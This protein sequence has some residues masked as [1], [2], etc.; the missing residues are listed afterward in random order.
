[1]SNAEDRIQARKKKLLRAASIIKRY[2]D[3]PR[4]LKGLEMSNEM[5]LRM[6]MEA[7]CM[8]E[9]AMLI[10]DIL[11]WLDDEDYYDEL[12]WELEGRPPV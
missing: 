9:T 1:M 10:N 11:K 12:A 3:C 5:L 8:L 2:L 7:G 6:G 4:E